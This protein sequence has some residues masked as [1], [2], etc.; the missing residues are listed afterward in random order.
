[1]NS[2]TERGWRKNQQSWRENDTAQPCDPQGESRPQ[3]PRPEPQGCVSRGQEGDHAHG[4]KQAPSES[5]CRN[6]PLFTKDTTLRNRCI[7]DGTQPADT[8]TPGDRFHS[9]EARRPWI[10]HVG[11]K[12][13]PGG[14]GAESLGPGWPRGQAL[15]PGGWAAAST[16]PQ[17]TEHSSLCDSIPSLSLKISLCN[18]APQCK[19][20]RKK[21]SAFGKTR[22]H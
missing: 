15:D 5:V 7:P 21:H 10:C 16:G 2:V 1:M 4:T 17:T 12:A 8:D 19:Y 11:V 3:E 6:T 14:S 20:L 22:G 13:L 18:A 9:L